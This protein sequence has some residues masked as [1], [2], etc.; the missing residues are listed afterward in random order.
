MTI[1]NPVYSGSKLV[2][3]MGGGFT[4]SDVTTSVKMMA[5]FIVLEGATWGSPSPPCT[6]MA[7]TTGVLPNCV[8]FL[9]AITFSIS[10]KFE[11]KKAVVNFSLQMAKENMIPAFVYDSFTL[12]N[13][14]RVI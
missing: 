12:P 14:P 7:V 11:G 1:F 4:T 10:P 13:E 5:K 2:C 6:K 3:L 9:P 8:G